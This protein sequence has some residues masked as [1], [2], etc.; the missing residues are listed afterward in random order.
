MSSA[1]NSQ[2]EPQ[3]TKSRL[4]FEIINKDR[5]TQARAGIFRTD[6][7]T[8]ETPIFMPVGTHGVV[9]ALTPAEL[10]EN[11]VQIIL[12]NT[13]H[14]YLRPGLEVIQKG[15]GLHR[16]A[17]WSKPI[18]TDSGGFQVFSLSHLGKISDEKI[19]FR[20]HIDGAELALSPEISM[21]IQNV[22]GAD[23][24][25]AF[26]ECTS[27]PCSHDEA[28]AAL[29]RTH[30]WER[31]S[32][33][34]FERLQPLYGHRQYLFGIIQGSIY[35]DLRAESVRVLTAL[36]FSG[37]AIGGLAVGEPKEQMFT[38]LAQTAPLLPEMKPRYLMGVGKPEDILR[39]IA[40]GVDMFDCVLPTRNARNGTL[41]TWQGRIV[42]KQAQ[43]RL[44][45]APPDPNCSC[46]ICRNFSRAY[47]RHLFMNG[48]ITGLRLN[49]VH[50]IHFFL[51]LVKVARQQIVQGQYDAW[52]RKFLENYPV[53]ADHA[54]ENQL[55]RAER[56]R[57]HIAENDVG[58]S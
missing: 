55:R 4:P 32:R 23:I 6:H 51:E 1:N 18:L 25:M 12:G 47:L 41:F 50:N 38:T 14:L 7:G 57:K 19:V 36:D 33:E 30:I 53:E 45:F 52:L 16:L 29:R 9:K 27:F 22:L 35:P 3:A 13:Y 44:D 46:Y 49:T 2:V 26:D 37:Y 8:V 5:I 11:G 21:D 54:E 28:Q 58:N 24:V 39:A 31:R 56:R 43:Y 10:E 42:L 17:A 20:S 40:L 34:Y 15:G 48:D